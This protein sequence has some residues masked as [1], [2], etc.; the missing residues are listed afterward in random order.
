MRSVL[1]IVLS[2]HSEFCFGLVMHF[3][4]RYLGFGF[5]HGSLEVVLLQPVYSVYY[6]V[7]FELMH[8]AG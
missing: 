2:A 4:V 5:L 1:H 7:D 3:G 8:F 6:G